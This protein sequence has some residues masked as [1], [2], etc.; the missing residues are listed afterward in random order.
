PD[1]HRLPHRQLGGVLCVTAKN[2]RRC[3]LWVTLDDFCMSAALSAIPDSG[4]SFELSLR[5]KGA[6]PGGQSSRAC[7]RRRELDLLAAYSIS[8]SGVASSPCGTAMP[9]VLAVCR[10]MTS[11]NLVARNTGRSAGF[12]PLSKRPV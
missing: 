2:G 10:L 8:W 1:R 12:S 7:L 4:H 11:S 6:C 9:N 5:R 3:P